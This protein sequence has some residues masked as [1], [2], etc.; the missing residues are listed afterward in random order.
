MRDNLYEV[1]SNILLQVLNENIFIKWN[2]TLI[3]HPA[4]HLN[5]VVLGRKPHKTKWM[6]AL[7]GGWIRLICFE[8]LEKVYYKEVCLRIL[9]NNMV[10]NFQFFK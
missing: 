4:S 6:S 1:P 2:Q 7:R 9:G 5:Q 3:L 8:S 10:S